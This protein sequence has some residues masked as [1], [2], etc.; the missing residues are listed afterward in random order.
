MPITP[1]ALAATANSMW[2]TS[3]CDQHGVF[4]LFALGTGNYGRGQSH[5]LAGF[6]QANLE[7]MIRSLGTEPTEKT[8]LAPGASVIVYVWIT[9]E[10]R[11][12]LRAALG[13][14][15]SVK[16][17]DYRKTWSCRPILCLCARTRS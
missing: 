12:D 17:G 15:F 14:R 1:T 13:Q 7:G 11:E 8:R 6:S 9:V 5:S 10:R 3:S 2:S 4:E 16:V